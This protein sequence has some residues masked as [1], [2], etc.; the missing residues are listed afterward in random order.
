MRATVCRAASWISP[1]AFIAPIQRELKS[2][3]VCAGSRILKIC[4]W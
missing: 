1:A 4:A 2:T 3:R